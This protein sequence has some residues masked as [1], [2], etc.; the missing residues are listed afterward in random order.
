MIT[1]AVYVAYGFNAMT[2]AIVSINTLL[3]HNDLPVTVISDR[4]DAEIAH[5]RIIQFEDTSRGARWAKLNID[6]LADYDNIV[7]LDAD[8][9]IHQSVTPAIEM[10]ADWDLIMAASENQGVGVMKH[11]KP[12]ERNAT[13]EEIG[14][15]L[16]LQL[17]AGVM[18]FNR[19]RCAKLFAAWREEWRRYQDQDQAALLRA[20]HREPVRLWLLSTDWNSARG[21]I[22]EHKFGRARA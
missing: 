22:V 1:G 7:Y 21:S 10:L 12:D 2:E 19:N 11:I 6:L 8:T 20:L 15:H 18:F 9:R 17:Q 16:P 13:K 14:N 4:P 3:H 5:T